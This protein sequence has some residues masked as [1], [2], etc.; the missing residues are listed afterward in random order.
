MRRMM[1]KKI[2]V[3]AEHRKGKLNAVTNELVSFA[4]KLSEQTKAEIEGLALGYPVKELSEEFAKKSGLNVIGLENKNLVFYSAEA[5]LLA[6][7]EFLAK[8]R[9]D[10]IIIA[11]SATGWDFAPA[12]AMALDGNFISG[13]IEF[14]P[15]PVR[16]V[17]RICGGK[18]LLEIEPIP[19]KI[20][21]LSLMPGAFRPVEPKTQGK[22]KIL[23]LNLP[24]LK[25]RALGYLEAKPKSLNLSSAEV[26]IAVGRGIGGAEKLDLIKN[27]AGC[28]ER[29]AI[30]ASRP[31]VD[32][33]WLGL[34]HQVGQTGQTVQPRLYIACGISG[35]IQHQVG[36]NKSEVIVAINTDPKAMIFN[37][38]HL[39][40][41][42]DIHKFLPI[43][44][45][46]IQELKAL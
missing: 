24:E 3:I 22:V 9:Y 41:I 37:L 46:K 34:E 23:N 30:G 5:Y 6:L 27:L 20:S 14:K 11:H 19:E 1:A 42:Q 45:R 16:F 39:G 15:E 18:I 26:I 4:Q 21:V 28:F 43:L 10:F 7:R 8:E 40:I 36:M 25:T 29:S 12:L 44:I 17:R 33:G 13:V 38:A 31:V 2:L 32:A 35:Q